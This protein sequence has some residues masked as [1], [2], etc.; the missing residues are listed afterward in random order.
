MLNPTNDYSRQ[1]DEFCTA[2][3]LGHHDVYQHNALAAHSQ[4]LTAHF[5]CTRQLMGDRVFNA[6][7]QSYY[8]WQQDQQ[9]NLNL[10]GIFF[11]EF[12][13]AQQM[14][15]AA[16]QHVWP[17]LADVARIE[18]CLLLLYYDE[19]IDELE[20]RL[21]SDFGKTYAL[22]TLVAEHH[23]YLDNTLLDPWPKHIFVRRHNSH[24][25]TSQGR[26]HTDDG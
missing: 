11:P 19:D 22:S 18:Y 15:A 5:P 14:S 7:A 10:Y 26:S 1:L 8:H 3:T 2:L 25:T 17:A 6:L 13:E 21:S 9:F 23:A 20:L 4:A 16:A 12:I 24:I